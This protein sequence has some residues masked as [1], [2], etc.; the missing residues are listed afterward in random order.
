MGEDGDIKSLNDYMV[1]NIKN[2]HEV[3]MEKQHDSFEKLTSTV[4]AF[5]FLLGHPSLN[6][7][8]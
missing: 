1:L 7:S 6:I 3:R 4:R 8:T 2:K 5:Y